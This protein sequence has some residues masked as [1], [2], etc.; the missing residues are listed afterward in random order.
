LLQIKIVEPLRNCQ[1]CA[2]KNAEF[3]QFFIFEALPALK[4]ET[5]VKTQASIVQ[6]F[7]ANSLF[8][9]DL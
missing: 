4:H 5:Y 7:L 3:K 8:I 1:T 6:F 2:G 9:N